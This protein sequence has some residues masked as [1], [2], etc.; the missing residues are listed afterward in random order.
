MTRLFIAAFGSGITCTLVA[1]SLVGQTTCL[2]LGFSAG[3]VFACAV[4]IGMGIGLYVLGRRWGWIARG[5]PISDSETYPR[6]Q[7]PL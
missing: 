7:N 3:I 1:I 5:T 6:P 4:V 2:A